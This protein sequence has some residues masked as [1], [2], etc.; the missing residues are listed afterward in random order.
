[1]LPIERAVSPGS[2]RDALRMGALM[3]TRELTVLVVLQV[4]DGAG[5][6]LARGS[7]HS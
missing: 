3:N 2:L 1:M 4:G 6:R 5:S 7:G